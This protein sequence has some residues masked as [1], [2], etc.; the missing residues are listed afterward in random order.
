MAQAV[1]TKGYAL[2][3]LFNIRRRLSKKRR[4][5]ASMRAFE[6]FT[7]EP[8]DLVIDAGANFG[9]ITLHLIGRGARVQAFEP[10]PVAFRHLQIAFGN[11]PQVECIQKGLSDHNGSAKLYLHKKQA[12]DAL[13]YS[14]ASS[15]LADKRNVDPGNAVEIELVDIAEV[16]SAAKGQVRLLKL[17]VE[18]AEFAILNRLI[19]TGLIHRIDQVFCETHEG[20]IPSLREAARE[21][22]QRLDREGIRH[23]NLDWV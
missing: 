17:D 12:D 10:N 2:A 13:H 16:V 18:G 23:V 21:L 3:M 6:R 5:K 4:Q 9:R 15:L 14:E 19:D 8:G 20:K 11:H 7:I 22:H 1:S